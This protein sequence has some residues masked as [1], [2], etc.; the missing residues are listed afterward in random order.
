MFPYKTIK[1]TIVGAWILA[2]LT[3]VSVIWAQEFGPL[4]QIVSDYNDESMR[5]AIAKSKMSIDFQLGLVIEQEMIFQHSLDPTYRSFNGY[6]EGIRQRGLD[7]IWAVNNH[8]FLSKP[9]QE[10]TGEGLIPDIQIPI[11]GLGKAFGAG[12][13]IKV[14]GNQK[15]TAGYDKTSYEQVGSALDAGKTTENNRINIKQ[16]QK[17]N[18][19]GVIGDRVHVLIDYDSEADI[20]KRSKVRLKYEGKEDEVLQSLEAGD[21]EFSLSGSSLVGGLTTVHKGLFG[22]KSVAR[23]GGLELTAIASK[24]EGQSQTS[25][26]TGG[27]K[28]D[29][30]SFYEKDFREHSV[31]EIIPEGLIGDTI[32]AIKVFVNNG[33]ISSN[34]NTHDLIDRSWRD[35]PK[36]P[37]D[38]IIRSVKLEAKAEIIDFILDDPVKGRIILTNELYDGSWLGVAYKTVKGKYYPSKYDF[39]STKLLMLVKPANC[40][41][42]DSINGYS[43]NYEKRNYYSLGTRGVDF[44]TLTM[45]IEYRIGNEWVEYDSSKQKSFTEILELEKNGQLYDYYINQ[46]EGYFFFPEDKPFINP[47]LPTVVNEIYDQKNLESY[48]PKYRFIITYKTSVAVYY[49]Q[50]PGRLLEGTV[51]VTL[52][53]ATVPSNEYT[54]DYDL[55]T[56]T[57]S[58]KIR[59]DLQNSSA[60]LNIDYQYLPSFA[61]GSK[62][63][64]GMRGIYKFGENGQLG[65]TWMYRSEQSPD[66][67]PRLGEEPRRIIVAGLDGSY[68][69]GVDFLT[70]W[71][72]AMPLVE[73]DV[74]ST[75][76]ISGEFAGNFPNPN[77]KGQVYIDDMDG[78][79]VSD[80]LNLSRSTW[81]RTSVPPGKIDSLLAET[82]YWYNPTTQVEMK[83]INPSITV[84]TQEDAKIT[85]LMFKYAAGHTGADTLG[86]WAGVTQLV[87]KTGLDLSQSKLLNLWIRGYKGIVHIDIG[88]N[89]DEDQVWWTRK[90]LHRQNNSVDCEPL[91][92]NKEPVYTDAS[93][94]GLDR[95]EGDD[96]NWDAYSRDDGTDDYYADLKNANYRKINGTEKN[97]YYDTEDLKM[98][99]L[100]TTDVP[101]RANNYYTFRFD[102]SQ[103]EPNI[104][105]WHQFAALLDTAR[106]V[107]S[108]L[109]WT[110]IQYAR[111]WVDS[112]P[113][114]AAFEIAMIDINGNRW[115]EQGVWGKDTTGIFSLRPYHDEVDTSERFSISVK[116]NRDDMDYASPPNTENK[117][118]QGKVEFEQSLCFNIDS[119]KAGHYAVARKILRS[120]ESNY[121]GY[122]KIKIWVH[123]NDSTKVKKS[124]AIRLIGNDTT[125]YYQFR[126]P[127]NSG[128]Q[129]FSIDL[130]KFSDLKKLP[131]SSDTMNKIRTDGIYS[132]KGNPSLLQLTRIALCVFNDDTAKIF[133]DE[134]WFDELR[135]DD[136]R[137]DRGT[138]VTSNASVNFADL[139]S[140][141][142]S[143]NNT[144]SHWYGI[145][146]SGTGSGVKNTSYALNGTFNPHKFYFSDLGMFFPVNFGYGN[147]QQLNE[148]GGDD[149]RLTEEESRAQMTTS[150]NANMSVS[151]SKNLTQ[152][153]LTNLTIDRI[154]PQF[155]WS[156]SISNSRI[157]ADST[158]RTELRA[159]YRWSPANNKPIKIGPGMQL[160]YLPSSFGLGWAR[161]QLKKWHWDKLTGVENITGSGE[162]RNGN[163]EINW[164]IMNSLSYSFST[165]RD[166]RDRYFQGEWAKRIGLGSENY[167]NQ[168]VNYRVN[169]NWLKLVKPNISLATSYTERHQL[170]PKTDIND[171]MHIMNVDNVN[172]MSLSDNLE[173]GKWLAKITGLRNKAK[174]DS[175][176]VG[177]PRWLLTRIDYL[178]NKLG[179]V[180]VSFSRDLSSQ[181]SALKGFRP[182]LIYQ[183]GFKQ[184]INDIPRYYQNTQDRNTIR[185]SYSMGTSLDLSK[186]TFSLSMRRNDDTTFYGNARSYKRS[187]TW[188]ELRVTF[189][190]ME[191]WALWRKA[192][193]SS[194][195]TST[196]SRAIDKTWENQKAL[197]SISTKNSFSPLLSMNN[198]WKKNVGN[199]ISFDYSSQKNDDV[200]GQGRDT[201]NQT[202]KASSSLSYSFS[203][204]KGFKINLWKLG[205]KRIKFNSD[206]SLQTQISYTIRGDRNLIPKNEVTAM[207]DL[208][209]KS[210]KNN[211]DI[212][213]YTSLI[214]EYT[215]SPSATY[216][217]TRSITGSASVDYS[218]T[219]DVI[220]KSNNHN[221]IAFSAAAEIKF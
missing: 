193:V 164:Q 10:R 135:L 161:S 182:D 90:G 188:P 12:A 64:A 104:Y 151:F 145:N 78:S 77:T 158:T 140:L 114:N 186:V 46:E 150:Q 203:A 111:I 130:K 5:G 2:F 106:A 72:N 180:N 18:L 25:T 43:W 204:P 91:N 96:G 144:G 60:N 22:L 197:V 75:F 26:F 108:Q 173:V 141:S 71:V 119:L 58:E 97:G 101:Q 19:E 44:S 49:L 4:E 124:F 189:A 176:E 28:K 177:S 157:S 21:T 213:G 215:I 61:L 74:P 86:A 105:G 125:G 199:S 195:M 206:L 128:W 170:A 7:S 148:Y 62:T 95:M 138:A 115:Q 147:S 169:L 171:S 40:Q 133:S 139:L 126:Q 132:L 113:V 194:N 134:V 201:Y 98:S 196:Y 123:S 15:I 39:D 93:D 68:Q 146:S 70:T 80:E 207:W 143:Y 99:G 142:A 6:L 192:M 191:K 81:V 50:A 168:K 109:G 33:Y 107:G 45:K 85:T 110:S 120:G 35:F 149:I 66:E 221:R 38:T 219:N 205:K 185:N 63:L 17:I 84:E 94:I 67:K 152:W 175:V 69:T 153:W 57:F 34:A 13:Q 14:N 131:V 82:F 31:F 179:G 48:N 167:R 212:L 88:R 116:N 181:V 117:D 9:A 190:G 51:K 137:R 211:I 79:K 218:S 37:R 217:F 59:N 23:I 65:G 200:I 118:E 103:S 83:E 87:S 29:S 127:I 220:A 159:G 89:I 122:E 216:N 154:S 1:K 73:T 172:S 163:G 214:H 36:T 16:E 121:T 76:K 202:F 11:P 183:F 178:F 100:D 8:A 160:Y 166:L 3:P 112:C 92:L 52:N 165:S 41:P 27:N 56:V 209:S 42:P 187:V 174:D 24:D 208:V 102:L 156:K 32:E 20:D 53:G 30:T 47:D 184:N 198:R 155:S 210:D 162:T 136:V 55:G 129:E 54:V